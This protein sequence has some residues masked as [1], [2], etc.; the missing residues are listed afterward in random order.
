MKSE[1]Q[2]D[3]RSKDS[4]EPGRR[5]NRKITKTNK[6]KVCNNSEIHEGKENKKLQKRST[7]EMKD[8][9]IKQEMK[10]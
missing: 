9:K 4:D 10:N 7:V 6:T 3:E 2:E 1:W 8:K 5:K